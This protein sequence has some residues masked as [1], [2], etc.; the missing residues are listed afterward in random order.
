MKMNLTTIAVGISLALA[1]SQTTAATKKVMDADDLK[2]DSSNANKCSGLDCL[3]RMG[4]FSSEK[5][6]NRYKENL[7]SKTD[8]QV[9]VEQDKK[10]KNLFHVIVGPFHDFAKMLQTSSELSRKPVKTTN[11]SAKN[12]ATQTKVVAQN[13][14]TTKPA[15]TVKS[16]DSTLG[17]AKPF[18]AITN[19]F[20]FHNNNLKPVNTAKYG[21]KR[22]TI[23]MSTTNNRSTTPHSSMTKHQQI[24]ASQADYPVNQKPKTDAKGNVIPLYKTGPYVGVSA[25][26]LDEIGKNPATAAYQAFSGT[27][28]AGAGHM[29]THRIYMGGEFYFGDDLT[30]KTYSPGQTGYSVNSGIFYGGDFIPGFMITDTVLGYLRIGGIR[31]HLNSKPTDQVASSV[32]SSI[33]SRRTNIIKNGWQVGAGTQTNLYKNLD[34]RAEYVFSHIKGIAYSGNAKVTMG[35]VNVGLVYKFA[36]SLHRA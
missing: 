5:Y 6:A 27:V 32:S 22:R 29:F 13:N 23:A 2:S 8:Q 35:Q 34:G 36:D 16:S 19:L 30:A 11:T 1:A 24:L 33:Y 21:N 14:V 20:K 26:V 28:S 3:L 17:I 31:A 10:N 25:G 18:M 12:T 15:A 4:T 7:A 9:K